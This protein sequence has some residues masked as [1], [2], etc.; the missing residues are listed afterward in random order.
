MLKIRLLRLKKMFQAENEACLAFKKIF[1]GQNVACLALKTT[2]RLE[3]KLL[4][5]QK[6]YEAQK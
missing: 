3:T 4:E 2:L 5:P 6:L 1:V